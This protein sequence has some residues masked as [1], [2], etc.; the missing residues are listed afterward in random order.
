MYIYI[1]SPQC[2]YLQPHAQLTVELPANRCSAEQCNVSPSSDWQPSQHLSISHPQPALCSFLPLFVV[3]R[4]IELTQV[5]SGTYGGPVLPHHGGG[6]ASR[7]LG[8]GVLP[9]LSNNQRIDASQVLFI[10][11]GPGKPECWTL[12]FYSLP[13]QPFSS[14]QKNTS[15]ANWRT[16]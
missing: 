14:A 8:L 3:P 15:H 2:I 4:G 1:L 7:L 9:S 10:Q 6:S 16:Q 11:R 5:H 12:M 13:Y